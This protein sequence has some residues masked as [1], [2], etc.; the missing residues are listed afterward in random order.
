MK[1]TSQTL[2]KIEKQKTK[3]HS[4]YKPL[5]KATMVSANQIDGVINPDRY[6]ETNSEEG[7]ERSGNGG[8]GNCKLAIIKLVYRER[9]NPTSKSHDLHASFQVPRGP[10]S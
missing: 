1:P 6:V 8:R 2:S 5:V 4:A 10:R 3:I 7:G 9:T